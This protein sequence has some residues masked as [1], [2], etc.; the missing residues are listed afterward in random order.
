MAVQPPCERVEPENRAI[1]HW[2]A[3]CHRITTF[4]MRQFVGKHGIE[5]FAFPLSPVGGEQDC[6]LKSAH[7]QWDIDAFRSC[8]PWKVMSRERSELRHCRRVS[9]SF[10]VAQQFARPCDA[11]GESCQEEQ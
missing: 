8:Q 5:F 7:S 11:C 1:Q 6:C 4:N 9:D 2:A 10:R 3:L